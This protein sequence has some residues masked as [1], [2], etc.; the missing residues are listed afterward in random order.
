MEWELI[1]SDFI[2][3]NYINGM[4]LLRN[5]FFKMCGFKRIYNYSLKNWCL[6]NGYDYNTYI[7]YDMFGLP[8]FLKDIKD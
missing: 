5:H 6:K 7:I 2:F 1:E 3:L 8:H 4:A